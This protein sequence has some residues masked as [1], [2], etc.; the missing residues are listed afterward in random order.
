[1]PVTR[2]LKAKSCF[3]AECKAI[4]SLHHP[5]AR[6]VH[7][8]R[9]RG[10][11]WAGEARPKTEAATRLSTWKHR[12]GRRFVQWLK[13]AIILTAFT[14]ARLKSCPSTNPYAFAWSVFFWHTQGQNPTLRL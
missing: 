7:A 4:L 12:D 8:G 14:A 11:Q 9:G 2:S 5:S 3:V 6:P 13:P 1:M 10:W